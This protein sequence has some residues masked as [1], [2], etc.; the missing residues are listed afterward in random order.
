[1]MRIK[2]CEV[3]FRLQSIRLVLSLYPFNSLIAEPGV[4]CWYV[5]TDCIRRVAMTNGNVE[6]CNQQQQACSQQLE[7]QPIV[8]IDPDPVPSQLPTPSWNPPVP[9]PGSQVIV[10]PSREYIRDLK[11]QRREGLRELRQ[12]QRAYR[13]EVRQI[14]RQ[15]RRDAR[16]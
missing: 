16:Q 3:K 7:P 8:I 1:M 4:S 11:Q 13:K 14:Q 2:R 12:S 5:Y 10:I 15:E 9:P 6:E